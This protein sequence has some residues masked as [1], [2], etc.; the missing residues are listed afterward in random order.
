M[1]A[2]YR[3]TI[4][5]PDRVGIVA[6]AADFLASHGASIVEANHHTDLEE[7]WFFM[8]H[9]IGDIQLGSTAF[10]KA[11]TQLA[12]RFE[13]RWQWHEIERRQRVALLAS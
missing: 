11:F 9:E 12:E 6:A 2:R 4:R 5:C 3:L 8:R 13:M 10:Q 7:G 1:L